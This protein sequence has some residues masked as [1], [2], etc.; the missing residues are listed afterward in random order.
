[1]PLHHRQ[2]PPVKTSRVIASVQSNDSPVLIFEA[3]EARPLSRSPF[4][5][6]FFQPH[7]RQ[8]HS[9]VAVSFRVHFVIAIECEAAFRAHRPLYWRVG[10]R[11]LSQEVFSH[12]IV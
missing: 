11:F 7:P 1:A 6:S 12:L 2:F 9:P 10:T 3:K 8:N 5:A 4:A